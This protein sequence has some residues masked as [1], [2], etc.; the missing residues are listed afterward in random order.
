ME[1]K[2]WHAQAHLP[3]E[4]VSLALIKGRS[5]IKVRQLNRITGRLLSLCDG[6]RN[7]MEVAGSFA[8]KEKIEGV[9]PLK[10][11]FHG[12]LLLSE[13]GLVTMKGAHA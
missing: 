7:V 10:A 11:G 3:A 9:S 4:R 12:L 1:F 2:T 6:S 13:Q 8:A 5:K